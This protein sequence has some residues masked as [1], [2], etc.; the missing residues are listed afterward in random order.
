MRVVSKVVDIDLTPA[1]TS[2]GRLACI[3]AHRDPPLAQAAKK[4][5]LS[6]VAHVPEAKSRALCRH[7]GHTS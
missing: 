7:F 2:A 6:P 3:G 5:S 4:H 1:P